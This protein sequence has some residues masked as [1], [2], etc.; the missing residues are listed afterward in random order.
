MISHR[1]Q[2]G[3]VAALCCVL[4]LPLFAQSS[5]NAAAEVASEGQQAI[6]QGRMLDAKAK[7]EKL[8]RMQPSVA[9][10]HATLAA[11]CFK[12]KEYD[13]A[14]SEIE[15]AQKLKPGLARLDSLL[16]LS[17]SELG[18]FDE[19]LPKLEK[20]FKQTPDAM[21]RRLCGLQLLRAYTNLGRERDAVQTALELNTHYSD[22]PE[23]LYHTGRIYGNYAYITMERL[24]KVAPNS[25]WMLQARGEANES[26]KSYDAAIAA[27]NQVLSLDPRRPG[28]HY[29]M[30]RVYLA[31][32]TE[33]QDSKDRDAAVSEFNAELEVDPRNGNA[34]YELAYIAAQAGDRESA[35]QGFE[36]MVHRFPNFEEALVGLGGVLLDGQSPQ[37][38]VAPLERATRIRP[39]DEVAW[40]RLAQAQ[41]AAGNK[42][43]QQKAL[44]EF[45]KLHN[46]TPVGLK[47]PSETQ[48]VS[49]QQLGSSTEQ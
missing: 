25:V 24:Q 30:G 1:L 4:A 20:G 32:F 39:N 37:D 10:V 6:A 7:F 26:Q 18:R 2:A 42:E 16:G 13:E 12:I 29:R 35:R 5:D 11:V 22:D 21:T 9:E 15:K 33:N 44:T 47:K 3:C 31:R 19:A 14:V 40:Y 38:A 49:P 48:D 27:F 8:A 41:R 17:L 45:R 34:A 46:S 28:I 23:V 36:A 43:E